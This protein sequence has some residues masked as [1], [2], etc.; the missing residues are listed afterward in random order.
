MVTPENH[1]PF[2]NTDRF[3]LIRRIAAGGM[4][5]VYEV[6]DRDLGARVALKTWQTGGWDGLFRFK[7]E[8][9]IVSQLRHRNLVRVHDLFV[10]EPH[11]FF[12]MELIE[13]TT[14]DL[15]LAQ[16]TGSDPTGPAQLTTLR[17]LLAQILD[18][19]EHL[20]ANGI[21]HRDLKPQNI[22]VTPD[23]DV[24]LV[25]FGILQ[26]VGQ[27]A[28]ER[29]LG[30]PAYVSPEAA[31]GA[32]VITPAADLYSLG[33][34]IH[35]ALTDEPLFGGNTSQI[36]D[37]HRHRAP[38]SLRVLRPDLPG[39]LTKT[40]AR[41]LRKA[42]SDRPTL[43][44]IREALL[45]DATPSRDTETITG[46]STLVGRATEL[47]I[48]RVALRRADA[49]GLSG[50]VL[51]GPTGV[52]KSRLLEETTATARHWGF[53]VLQGRCYEREVVPYR[54]FDPLVDRLCAELQ[55]WPL[56]DLLPLA[57]PLAD[58][59]R[60]FAV[61]RLPLTRL[62]QDPSK[63]PEPK[64]LDSRSTRAV[65]LEAV[66]RLI[67][68]AAR[69]RPVM[70]CIDDWEWSGAEDA[71]LLAE[72][73]RSNL[74]TPLLVCVS[75]RDVKTAPALPINATD[76]IQLNPLPPDAVANAVLAHGV[77]SPEIRNAVAA[78]AGGNL[79][80]AQELSHSA[81]AGIPL[82]GDSTP[83]SLFDARI[84]RLGAN[85]TL[86]LELVSVCRGPLAL[87][88]VR[89]AA[90]LP[91]AVFFQAADALADAHLV[92]IVNPPAP[93]LSSD[94]LPSL[95]TINIEIAHRYHREAIQD[96][97]TDDEIVARHK[98]IGLALELTALEDPDARLPADALYFHW[99]AAQDLGRAWKYGCIAA[100]EAADRLAWEAA[101][102]LYAAALA[103]RDIGGLEIARTWRR[104]A[105]LRG[106]MGDTAASHTA[107]EAAIDAVGGNDELTFPDGSDE[108]A[109]LRFTTSVELAGSQIRA[110]RLHEGEELFER[111][112]GTLGLTLRR[113]P[114]E[115]VRT[116]TQ[117]RVR[118]K[119]WSLLPDA[120]ML[121][122]APSHADRARLLL[123]EHI[124]TDFAMVRPL[125]MAEAQMRYQ[126][127]ARRCS[128]DRCRAMDRCLEAAFLSIA[129]RSANRFDK[130]TTMLEEAAALASNCDD[131]A[132]EM[133][134]AGIRGFVNWIAGR[135]KEARAQLENVVR[136]AR[137][138]GRY[139]EYDG[140]MARHWLILA[141][142][143]AGDSQRALE[144][145]GELIAA[146]S[147]NIVRY[148]RGAQ[149]HVFRL[150][151]QGQI[152]VA[153]ELLDQW[154]ECVAE[155]PVTQSRFNLEVAQLAVLCGRSEY[156]AVVEHVTQR[157]AAMHTAGCQ[158]SSWH[159][160]MWNLPLLEAAACSPESAVHAAEAVSKAA[161][162]LIDSAPDYEACLVHAWQALAA[163]NRGDARGKVAHLD[164]ALHKSR[165]AQVPYHRYRVLAVARFLGHTDHDE[166]RAE[167]ASRH[168]YASWEPT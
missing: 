10:R 51:S 34:I 114:E 109:A 154:R 32:A 70:L 135:W 146:G 77:D 12:T 15:H 11:V 121:R 155:E 160:A 67:G 158:M 5:N 78:V 4:G 130:A 29:P 129:S 101:S 147:D 124:F 24:T 80:L 68:A 37:A 108:F 166:E 125:Y 167:L 142:H 52:G 117:L 44:Q 48:C 116:L 82:F 66:A 159:R 120:R 83:G 6:E 98:A 65:A 9:R 168:N 145:G 94:D 157:T 79:L 92:H 73:L 26:E 104:L 43:Q 93:D 111:L 103:S 7:R 58:A 53:T 22:L 85:E 102:D 127:T 8:F 132:L 25:D 126:L 57:R 161:E 61:L 81:L 86:V 119:A 63:A 100:E 42:P 107:L 115:A 47:A 55:T 60:V 62:W 28:P 150:L 112:L 97:M 110:G 136:Q 2:G 131:P 35:E 144:L 118:I 75:V 54:T 56:S 95:G 33:V 140:F 99:D 16:T 23:G 165:T 84:E 41:M 151:E 17:P 30:T 13:G 76:T 46:L 164:Q 122:R 19:L 141:C 113:T 153:A 133:R 106:L 69:R 88:T 20:H 71:L 40:V 152:D 123:F 45:L 27:R 87:P 74:R 49:G 3:T 148:S 64:K 50:L 162:D 72:V 21:V 91:A 96:R 39:S 89:T 36:V 59:A 31:T 139:D 38:P 149:V 156:R 128:D 143:Y 18:A 105:E 1:L 134:I 163:H 14:L 138:R 90:G 137:L